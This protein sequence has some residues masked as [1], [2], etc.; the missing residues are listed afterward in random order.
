MEMDM[1]KRNESTNWRAIKIVV[2]GVEVTGTY[3]VD[4]SDLMTVQMDGGGTKRARGGPAA[5]GVAM[6]IL[7]ELYKARNGREPST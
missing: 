1:P 2:D 4:G 7:G 6:V 5:E 3:S